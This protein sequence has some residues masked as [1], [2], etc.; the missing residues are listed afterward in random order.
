ISKHYARLISLW[1]AD[2]L[3][4]T[5]PFTK[6]LSARAAQLSKPTSSPSNPTPAKS[7]PVKSSGNKSSAPTSATSQPPFSAKSE[8]INI[9]A[10]YSLLENRYSKR[11]PVSPGLLKPIS[12]PEYYDKL[13][14]ELRD[15]PNKSWLRAKLD[16]W[17]M[18]VRW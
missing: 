3:R 13:M 8:L 7:S 9:N 1:P 2:P 18:K 11:Y 16:E 12:N 15:A 14:Q 17:K 4:S 5:S 10:V 6:T